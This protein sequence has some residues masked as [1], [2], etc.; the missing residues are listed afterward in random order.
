[1]DVNQS[2]FSELLTATEHMRYLQKE[3]FRTKSKTALVEAKKAEIHVDSILSYI[4]Q[5]K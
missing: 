4:D 2:I 3:Y 5:T 1:M